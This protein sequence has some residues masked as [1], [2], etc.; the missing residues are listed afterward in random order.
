MLFR[1][2]PKLNPLRCN[3]P[4]S[5]ETQTKNENHPLKVKSCP[6]KLKPSSLRWNQLLKMKSPLKVKPPPKWNLPPKSEF[7]PPKNEMKASVFRVRPPQYIFKAS[8]K[9]ETSGGV[10]GHTF[11]REGLGHADILLL[12]SFFSEV[13]HLVASKDTS[14]QQV[15][16]FKYLHIENLYRRLP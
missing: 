5:N 2:N 16:T 7:C 9:N 12:P 8:I 13:H 10:L 11:S 4:S 6:L 3:Q 14:I 1:G 15:T